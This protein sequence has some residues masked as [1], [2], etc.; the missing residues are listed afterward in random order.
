MYIM[1][2]KI[3]IALFI[4]LQGAR[5]EKTVFLTIIIRRTS[6]VNQWIYFLGS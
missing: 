3:N 2:T 1:V 4:S 5:V 6:F